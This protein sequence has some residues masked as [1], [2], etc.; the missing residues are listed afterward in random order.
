[1]ADIRDILLADGQAVSLGML[2]QTGDMGDAKRAARSVPTAKGGASQ[3]VNTA[4]PHTVHERLNADI[5]GRKAANGERLAAEPSGPTNPV[6]KATKG[7]AGTAVV[8]GHVRRSTAGTGLRVGAAGAVQPATSE[9]M[10]ATAGETAPNSRRGR[11]RPKIIGPRPWELEGIPK[12]T[13]YRRKA[14][15]K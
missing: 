2:T 9:I 12:R 7:K 10:D 5:V 11:G 8:K 4:L 14:E 13:W 1:M 15:K 6:A 3:A